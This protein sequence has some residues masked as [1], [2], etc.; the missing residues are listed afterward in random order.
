MPAVRLGK[1]ELRW[2]D[3][4][5]LPIVSSK[6][7]STCAGKTRYVEHTPPGDIRPAFKFDIDLI[8]NIIDTQ[9]GEGCGDRYLPDNGVVIMN[10]AP[11]IDRLDEVI[12]DGHVQGSLRFDLH[13]QQYG[14]LMRLVGAKRILKKITKNYVVVDDGAVEPILS[15]SNV[16]APGIVKVS[17]N[18]QP[19]DQIFVLDQNGVLLGLGK[20]YMS[21]QDMLSRS[22]GIAVKVRWHQYK[23]KIDHECTNYNDN[24]N[25]DNS[26]YRADRDINFNNKLPPGW[27]LTL[28][29]NKTVLDKIVKNAE[30]FI[31]STI[32][33]YQLPMAVS[34]SGGKDSL[35]VLSLVL[36]A[37]IKP[38]LLFI[39]TG[40]EFPETVQHVKDIANKFGLK[41]MSGKP[42]NEFWTGLS[43][44]GPPGKDYR[45]CCKTCKLGPTTRLIKEHF[46]EGVLMFIGQRRYESEQRSQKGMVWRN[47]WVPGQI[48]ASPIQNWTAL[49]IWLYIFSRGLEF[50][51][52]Y[53]QGLERI[54]CWL[55][56]SSDM[57]DF[58]TINQVKQH[59]DHERWMEALDKYSRSHQFSPDWVK[60]GL[61]RW[62]KLPRGIE[63]LIKENEIQIR[64]PA[65]QSTV[66]NDNSR[67]FQLHLADGFTDCKYGLSQEGAFNKELDMTRVVNLAN[68][69]GKPKYDESDGYCTIN[70]TIDIFPEGA[71]V[72]KGK[73]PREIKKRVSKLHAVVLR[74]M[75]CIGCGVCIGRCEN[76][77]LDLETS[78]EYSRIRLNEEKCISCG[79][80]LGPCP[81]VSFNIAESENVN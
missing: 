56:P 49:H 4:C 79:N 59:P 3:N 2:C 53:E 64:L 72:V 14:F 57:A 10:R 44:F 61:W 63:Q 34:F 9:F 24:Y 36:D 35:A 75:E 73:T 11:D 47:P 51:T 78:N 38:E 66:Q 65:D 46:P 33:K 30:N 40:L 13:R 8:R 18:I 45:W 60:Y 68:I 76:D 22:H 26:N 41:L 1:M 55:C 29:A 42:I 5:N 15:G 6:E 27:E 43:Y 70:N 32:N 21:S 62:K 77:A 48:G 81:V 23:D 16:L 54:G 67:G 31:R 80:C 20:A 74:A 7:C 25:D 12:F 19:G 50:N 71:I 28:K 17:D 58:T 39:D 69:L 52:L 37:G